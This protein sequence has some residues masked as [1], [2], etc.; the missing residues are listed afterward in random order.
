MAWPKRMVV[1]PFRFCDGKSTR[2]LANTIA[3][4]YSVP[5]YH[6][7]AAVPFETFRDLTNGCC[8]DSDPTTKLMFCLHG[9]SNPNRDV[10]VGFADKMKGMGVKEVGLVSFK[11]C[12]FGEGPFLDYLAQELVQREINFGFLVGYKSAVWLLPGGR[13]RGFADDIVNTLFNQSLKKDD[14][15]DRIR[16]VKGALAGMTNY[17]RYG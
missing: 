5:S 6:R 7:F 14:D 4:R 17:D 11:G 3:N 8:K 10:A 13:M 9:G 1:V 2:L 12:Q 15:A 16:V